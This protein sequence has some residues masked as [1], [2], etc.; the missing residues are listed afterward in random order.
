M[1]RPGSRIFS[2]SD[3]A[4]IIFW[5]TVGL[6]QTAVWI[7]LLEHSETARWLLALTGWL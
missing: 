2:A 7:A 5:H 6:T 1:L 4:G 3:K